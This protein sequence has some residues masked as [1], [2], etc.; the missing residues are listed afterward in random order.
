MD[1]PLG[2]TGHFHQVQQLVDSC[3]DLGPRQP[4]HS[5]PERHVAEYVHMGKEGQVLEHQAESP[6][7]RSLPNNRAFVESNGPGIGLFQSG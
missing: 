7:M 3:L 4:L 1:L 5:E 2:V 6:L